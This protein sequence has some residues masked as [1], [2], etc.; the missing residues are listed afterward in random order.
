MSEDLFEELK[1]LKANQRIYKIDI[2]KILKVFAKKISVFDIMEST[3]QFKEACKYVPDE[4]KR[5]FDEI[6]I[7]NFYMRVKDI[8]DNNSNYEEYVDKKEFLE[9]INFIKNQ[10]NEFDDE[11]YD[12]KFYNRRIIYYLI[13]L[14][15][16]YILDEPI[17]HEGSIFPGHTT[18]RYDNGIY[19][20]PVKENNENNPKA[21]CKFCIA[22]QG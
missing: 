5:Y 19:L 4:Y 3:Q 12:N 10:F 20:C 7:K 17:H 22:I 2:L 13:C 16:T 9:T 8:I 18:I 14:Y 1:S 11:I 15:T 6:Y 21:V